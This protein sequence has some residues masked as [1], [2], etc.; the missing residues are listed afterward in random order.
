[1]ETFG[2][3]CKY[4]LVCRIVGVA[5]GVKWDEKESLKWIRSSPKRKAR[6][7]AGTAA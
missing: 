3:K 1:M 7:V 2:L 6:V 5:E 4:W